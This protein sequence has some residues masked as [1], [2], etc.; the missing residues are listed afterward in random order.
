MSWDK[1]SRPHGV[2]EFP[3][4]QEVGKYVYT[5]GLHGLEFAKALKEGRILVGECNGVIIVPPKTFCPDHS[6][7]RL[8]EYDGDWEVVTYTIVYEDMYGNRLSEPQVIAVIRPLG[9]SGPGMIH[10]VK[11]EPG[12]LRPGLA[13][14]PVF[15][16]KEERKGLITDIAY[17]EPI[18]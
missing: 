12:R 15:K 1:T 14:R 8:V 13:V 5:P 4:R 16:P 6:E 7:E 11:A 18:E 10:Y 2:V 3:G 9:S 17:F